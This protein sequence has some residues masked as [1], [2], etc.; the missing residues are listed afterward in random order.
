MAHFE[1]ETIHMESQLVPI[2]LQVLYLSCSSLIC[3]L[4]VKGT[5]FKGQME[6][7]LKLMRKKFSLSLYPKVGSLLVHEGL[8]KIKNLNKYNTE[9][10]V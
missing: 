1:S 3:I 10:S 6:E 8:I 4:Y 9:I 7:G 2:D 5:L